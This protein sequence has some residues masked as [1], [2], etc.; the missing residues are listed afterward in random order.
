MA[1]G[2]LQAR[3][4]IEILGRPSETVKE[5]LNTVVV[6]MGTEK[7]VKILEKTYHKPIP[8]KDVKDLF[9]AFAE[10]SVELDSLANYFGLI[11]GYL[12][13]NIEIINPEKFSLLNQELNELGHALTQRLHNYD[14]IAKRLV[15][16]R[17]VLAKRLNESGIGLPNLNVSI[18]DNKQDKKNNK[19]DDKQKP[20]QKS[21]QEKQQK[22]KKKSG[23][24]T[25]K[26]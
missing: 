7:G 6:K 15:F 20:E 11:F 13:A 3:L 10:V 4:I 22:N 19:Q 26:R 23:T 21:G 17:D 2:K 12:P 8:V 9:T 24:K 14:A 25:R 16:E 18:A 5:A 1:D